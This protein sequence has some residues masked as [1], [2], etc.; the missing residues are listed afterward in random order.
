MHEP[1]QCSGKQIGLSFIKL[2]RCPIKNEF[3]LIIRG[4]IEFNMSIFVLR[5]VDGGAAHRDNRLIPGDEILQINGIL[6]TGMRLIDAVQL[7][8]SKETVSFLIKRTGKPPPSISDFF[9]I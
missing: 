1:A 3:G 8:R 7:V 5:L 4:G 6:T 9:Q 2:N